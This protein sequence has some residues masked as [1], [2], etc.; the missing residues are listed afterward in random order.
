MRTLEYR[1][2]ISSCLWNVGE[3]I[4]FVWIFVEQVTFQKNKFPSIVNGLEARGSGP[5]K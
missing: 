1:L 3:R 5:L 4:V 2:A